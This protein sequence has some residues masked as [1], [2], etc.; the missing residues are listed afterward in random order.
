VQ[1]FRFYERLSC[2][3]LY[4][5]LRAGFSFEDLQ[6]MSSEERIELGRMA[7]LD[8]DANRQRK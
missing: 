5:L 3:H 2:A 8:E 7:L 6:K 1:D 4:A